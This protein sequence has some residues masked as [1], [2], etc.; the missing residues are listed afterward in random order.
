MRISK[1]FSDENISLLIF[2]KRIDKLFQSL[3]TGIKNK[4]FFIYNLKKKI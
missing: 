1:I 2:F 4:N 3:K